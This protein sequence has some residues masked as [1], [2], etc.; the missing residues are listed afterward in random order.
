MRIACSLFEKHFHYGLAILLNSLFHAG[1]K[2]KFIA[3]YRGSLPFW[4]KKLQPGAKKDSYF[5]SENFTLEFMNLETPYHFTHFKPSFFNKILEEETA[6][7]LFYF[8]PDIILKAHWAF[9]T[10]WVSNGIA[11]C[12]DVNSCMPSNHPI[13]CSWKNTALKMGLKINRESDFF[14]NG[15]FVALNS[16]QKDFFQLW[17]KL[18]KTVWTEDELKFFS[19]PSR[20]SRLNSFCIADQDALN[21]ALMITEHPISTIGPEAMD[22]IH[23]GKIMSHAIGQAKPWTKNFFLAAINGAPPTKADKLFWEFAGKGPIKP[24]SQNQIR[25]KKL[26]LLAGKIIGRFIRRT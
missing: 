19:P 14:Y 17:E 18:I 12:Q 16:S 2:G 3:G 20:A 22:F 26:D 1:F 21:L 23:G 9:M 13:K 15:G 6:E 24:F 10:D 4:I 8:D 5:L 25:K 7:S 11:V